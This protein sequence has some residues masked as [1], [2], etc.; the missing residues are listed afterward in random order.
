MTADR[1]VVMASAPWAASEERAAAAV[2]DALEPAALLQGRDRAVERGHAG[3]DAPTTQRDRQVIDGEGAGQPGGDR[4]DRLTLPTQP[5]A[6]VGAPDLGKV[7][8]RSAMVTQ[9]RIILTSRAWR[10]QQTPARWVHAR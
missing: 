9:V 6:T 2:P 3:P 8:H 7:S 10:D 4:G 1:V 5:R